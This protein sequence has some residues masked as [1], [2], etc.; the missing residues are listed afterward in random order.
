M[1]PRAAAA[2]PPDEEQQK[3]RAWWCMSPPQ[4]LRELRVDPAVGLS[5][6]EA[7][8]RLA[9]YG[10][11]ELTKEPGTPMWKLILQQFDDALVKVRVAGA[12]VGGAGRARAPAKVAKRRR[13]RHRRAVGP[14][15]DHRAH[16][17]N[18]TPPPPQRPQTPPNT[19]RPNQKQI[20]LAAAAVSFLL[21]Y[22]DGGSEEHPSEEGLRA[23]LEPAVIL[24]ILALNAAVGVWQESNAEAALDALKRLQ[25][26][27]ARVVRGGRLVSDLP[28][29]L[30]VPGDVVELSAGDRVPADL[31]LVALKTAT[32]R[33][34]QASLTGESV[35]VAKTPEA[36]PRGEEDCELQGKGCMLF[37]G[38][39]V[40][41]GSGTG[42]VVATGMATEIGKIQ[43]QIASVRS[44]GGGG[45]EGGAGD[46][47][48]MDT[49]L[50]RRLDE[51]GELL[52]RVIFWVCVLVW[53]INYHHFA[54]LVLAPCGRVLGS[55]AYG[56]FG[57]A[58]APL[59]EGAPLALRELPL[60]VDPAR[61]S[62][63]LSKATYYFKIA[64]ALAVA[65][66]PEGL[67]A[68][69]TTCLALGTR[70][71]ARRNA[72]VR[73]LP[74]VET[75]GCTTVICS[76]KTGTLTTNQM[77]AVLLVTPAAAAAGGGGEGK[78]G[79]GGGGGD[80][81]GGGAAA[82]TGAAAPARSSAS[83][84]SRARRTTRRPA[85]SRPSAA[86]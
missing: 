64:V 25:G 56:A 59:F 77:S 32:L 63:S 29:A 41:N 18:A 33:A 7:E 12:R 6:A 45:G 74:S 37:A 34:E 8:E 36:L 51:F 71:M 13:R 44:G 55:G 53:L 49:P 57:R 30:L 10:R 38:T 31:R 52:A 14:G 17:T 79:G 78:G 43:A 66:I 81:G 39:A 2:G 42:V 69:I 54:H 72:I 46:E 11:N 60:C 28:A 24:L 82:P 80:G 16:H 67:P 48:S 1:A 61:S 20:L 68:V 27:S 62:F 83:S 65:A 84:R 73:K 23:F 9:R 58:L 26:D 85:P 19:P 3:T 22:F 40:S 15:G 86:R 4:V 75:L 21:A 76:D 47:P 35:A 50:K 70:K 5:G